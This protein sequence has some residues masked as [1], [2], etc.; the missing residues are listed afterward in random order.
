MIEAKALLMIEGKKWVG[1]TPLTSDVYPNLH[2]LVKHM[3]SLEHGVVEL[4]YLYERQQ[5]R[6]QD[7]F[8]RVDERIQGSEQAV[9]VIYRRLPYQVENEVEKQTRDMRTHPFWNVRHRFADKE[10]VEKS[11]F[12]RFENLQATIGEKC[13]LLENKIA[14]CTQRMILSPP[15]DPM[16]N[17]DLRQA[18]TTLVQDVPKLQNMLMAQISKQESTI[19][20]LEQK[21]RTLEIRDQGDLRPK[22]VPRSGTPSPD[23]PTSS[24]QMHGGVPVMP[25]AAPLAAQMCVGHGPTLGGYGG[26]QATSSSSIAQQVPRSAASMVRNDTQV[27]SVP[28]GPFDGQRTGPHCGSPD[29]AFVNPQSKIVLGTKLSEA[30]LKI[31]QDFSSSDFLN[32]E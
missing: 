28:R 31:R 8:R 20:L 13:F 25:M 24:N 29:V 15:V 23:V 18:V 3:T 11:M 16:G 32:E 7:I 4:Q 27:V 9:Q 1:D 12:D 2:E 26:N 6:D 10:Q 19:R 17:Q 22:A 21:I 5:E 14:D 30:P